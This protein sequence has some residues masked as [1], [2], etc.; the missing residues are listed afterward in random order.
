LRNRLWIQDEI[1]RYPETLQEKVAQPLFIVGLPR[2]GSTLLQR[3]LSE[4]PHC[5]PLLYWETFQPAPAPHP[6]NHRSDPR[7]KQAEKEMKSLAVFFS[8]RAYA[9]MHFAD[10]QQPE[11]CWGL[12]QNTLMFSGPFAVIA[13]FPK[14]F[15]WQQEQDMREA[16][17]SYKLQLQ[18]L[19]RNFPPAHWVLKSSDHLPYLDVLLSTFPDACIVH[20]HRDPKEVVPSFCNISIK[21]LEMTNELDDEV[22]GQIPQEAMDDFASD[23][24][25]AMAAR[26][27][28][29]PRSFFDL[30]YRDLVH[31]PVGA[32]RRIYEYFGYPFGQEFEG[33][34]VQWV[35]DNPK[36]K[37]GVH[38]Y[39]LEQFALTSEQVDSQ[40]AA[41]RK[42]FGLAAE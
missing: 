14:Y 36:E 9:A 5:R 10:A 13:N 32:I 21:S 18:I 26:Q 41:Y 8:E 23:I 22:I 27:H 17:A 29:N 16:Y 31:D 2:T 42:E 7:I 6:R 24:E 40:F 34:I 4:D 15:A 38:R 39:S 19:Q 25:Q 35:T 1:K 30:H 33:R 11:E 28:A 3:L 12:L 20:L 37:H